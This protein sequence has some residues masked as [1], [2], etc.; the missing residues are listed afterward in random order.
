LERLLEH[1]A[2][3]FHKLRHS[4]WIAVAFIFSFV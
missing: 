1:D 2:E 4:S 3:Y